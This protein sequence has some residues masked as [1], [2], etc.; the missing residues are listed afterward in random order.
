VA[1]Q[2]TIEVVMKSEPLSRSEETALLARIAFELTIS[3]RHTYEAGTENVLDPQGLRAY[4]E[5]LHRVTSAV[6]SHLSG[7]DGFSL[8][9][10]LE[11]IRTFGAR[12]NRAKEMEWVL[13]R[14]LP[15]TK[16]G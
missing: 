4:N 2:E 11:M 8:E 15:Q 3:A 1:D 6:V 10:I 13:D 5:L 7:T 9:T 12:H 16:S 14:V